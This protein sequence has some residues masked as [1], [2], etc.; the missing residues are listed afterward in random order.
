MD[1]VASL[2]SGVSVGLCM[3]LGEACRVAVAMVRSDYL[4]ALEYDRI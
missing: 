3:L 1:S 4:H 2:L